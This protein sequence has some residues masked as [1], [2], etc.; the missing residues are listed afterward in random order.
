[1]ATGKSCV[2]EAPVAGK[3]LSLITALGRRNQVFYVLSAS[4]QGKN[5]LAWLLVITAVDPTSIALE[6]GVRRGWDVEAGCG[7]KFVIFR[8]GF[9]ST[10]KIT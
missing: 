10:A 5:P 3:G 8:A 1:M 2:Q 7:A 6:F 9:E 4:S